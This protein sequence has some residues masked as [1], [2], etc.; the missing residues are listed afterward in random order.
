MNP[1]ELIDF[2][3][4]EV[5]TPMIYPPEPALL[6]SGRT[7]YPMTVELVPRSYAQQPEYWGIE[8]VG[9]AESGAVSAITNVPYAVQLDLAGCLG[10]VGVEVIGAGHTE[11]IPVSHDDGSARE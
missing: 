3:R 1:N 10:T 8:V 4:A 11:K 5:I 6:V 9:R 2:E 7:P